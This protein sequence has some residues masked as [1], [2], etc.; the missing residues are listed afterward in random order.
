MLIDVLSM[1]LQARRGL[2]HFHVDYGILKPLFDIMYTCIVMY[3]MIIQDKRGVVIEPCSE[4]PKEPCIKEG[5]TT[6]TCFG[7]GP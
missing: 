1:V 5:A 7:Y 2:I 4:P 3:N 6:S